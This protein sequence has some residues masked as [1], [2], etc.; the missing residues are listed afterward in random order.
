MGPPTKKL[1]TE[2]NSQSGTPPIPAAPSN[3][4]QTRASTFASKELQTGLIFASENPPVPPFSS[5]IPHTQALSTIQAVPQMT[6]DLEKDRKKAEKEQ[7]DAE[8]QASLKQA[9]TVEMP[10]HIARL[11]V[12]YQDVIGN[13]ALSKD[14]TTL[15]LFGV[16]SSE[17]SLLSIPVSSFRTYP[18]VSMK[19]SDPMELIVYVKD[20]EGVEIDYRFN[21]GLAAEAHSQANIIRAKLS[22]AMGVHAKTAEKGKKSEVLITEE[23][24]RVFPFFCEK[25]KNRWKN[26]EGLVYHENRSQGPCNKNWNR[27]EDDKRAFKKKEVAKKEAAKREAEEKKAAEEAAKPKPTLKIT[28][29]PRKA[30]AQD[31]GKQ[32]DSHEHEVDYI[33]VGEAHADS[34][35]ASYESDT[36][37]HSSVDSIIEWAQKVS[38]PGPK[39]TSKRRRSSLFVDKNPLQAIV[40]ETADKNEAKDLV[41]S[42]SFLDS[43]TDL[44]QIT[45][46]IILGLVKDNYGIFP[47]DRSLWYAV[48]ATS[49]KK[50][51]HQR[52]VITA[53]MCRNALITL[54][55]VG[56]LKSTPIQ[57]HD[58][59]FKIVQRHIITV[60]S[61]DTKSEIVVKLEELIQEMHPEY[62]VP[63]KFAPEEKHLAVLRGVKA[64]GSHNVEEPLPKRRKRDS[65]LLESS[66]TVSVST[67][68]EEFSDHENMADEAL[69]EDYDSGSV[70]DDI[71]VK[72]MPANE[73][74]YQRRK[75]L[76]RERDANGNSKRHCRPNGDR[77]IRGGV[78]SLGM[79][80]KEYPSMRRALREQSWTPAPAFLQSETGAWVVVPP[81]VQK[82]QKPQYPKAKDGSKAGGSRLPPYSRRLPEPITY[83][84]DPSGA[85]S[86][87]PFGH[88]VKPIYAR[89]SRMA[90]GN[91]TQKG[92][93]ERRDNSFRPVMQP[94]GAR[95]FLPG[96]PSK[97][98]L[99]PAKTAPR[100]RKP[101]PPQDAARDSTSASPEGADGGTPVESDKPK[102]VYNRRIS[103]IRREST[104]SVEPSSPAVS[105]A[106]PKRVTRTPRA[107]KM[108]P[109]QTLNFFLPQIVA[110]MESL[111]PGLN[112]L[113]SNFGLQHRGEAPAVVNKNCIEFNV[114]DILHDRIVNISKG[115]PVHRDHAITDIEETAKWEQEV[116]K[117]FFIGGTVAPNHGWINHST[118]SFEPGFDTEVMVLKWRDDTAF[119]VETLPYQQLDDMDVPDYEYVDIPTK[120][121]PA[122]P[123]YR[124]NE[125]EVLP[126]VEKPKRN[127]RKQQEPKTRHVTVLASRFEHIAEAADPVAAGKDLG[128][129]V[130]PLDAI[131]HKRRKET[132][133]SSE[134][135]MRLIIAVV[136]IRIITGG[137]EKMID[138]TLVATVFKD[139]GFTVNF[140]Y[141]RWLSLVR[142]KKDTIDK[143]TPR[144][145]QAFLSAY[146][147]GD[148]PSLDYDNLPAYNW[149]GL[150]DWGMKELGINF[151]VKH[152]NLPETRKALGKQYHCVEK[153][154]D[155]KGRERYYN[156]A[157]G[158]ATWKRLQ[159]VANIPAVAPL[160]PQSKHLSAD[161]IEI[162]E[163]MLAKS[164]VRAAAMTP[165][166]DYDRQI[167]AEKFN[168]IDNKI[169]EE[170]IETLRKDKVVTK[171]KKQVPG[172]QYESSY[173]FSQVI[174]R[175]QVPVDMILQAAEFKR[176]LDDEFGN[177]KECV[178]V[179]ETNEGIV[180]VITQLQ[181]HGRIRL[182]GVNIPM[183]KFSFVPDGGYDTNRIPRG[184]FNFDV[185]IYPTATYMY[186]SD[187]DVIQ[188][189]LDVD[190]PRGGPD[191]ELPAWYG[192]TD[193]LIPQLWA[194]ILV[195]FSGILA[196][197]TGS[198]VATLMAAYKS[199]LEEWEIRRLLE[200]GEK[201][202]V[203]KRLDDEVDG[204]TITEWWWAVIGQFC[205]V[206]NS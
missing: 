19:G 36:S 53:E 45:R 143:L 94:V 184:Q 76:E 201:N 142:M 29:S 161:E 47:G 22:G 176:L 168:S 16:Q 118:T 87:R 38:V 31:E 89:P 88:G 108:D 200:W 160:L 84:Q 72:N 46:D 164:L 204:W 60:P 50:A 35:N 124:M 116:A 62:Y 21:I 190:P 198:T 85:W 13:I 175:R 12:K 32:T 117:G 186:N 189:I 123:R 68:H 127:Q 185:D 40:D 151:G 112:T 130:V 58:N 158:Q 1:Q 180:M 173:Q 159:Y 157:G 141:K 119:T 188:D 51:A 43:D 138:W 206:D 183:S 163:S 71:Y 145:Q 14:H 30:V 131:A 133:M 67:D 49:L 79:P 41:A 48:F 101:K 114:D 65:N 8:L 126:V 107:A 83:M 63:S 93:L 2:A 81:R 115:K 34:L 162:D 179:G 182:Q 78:A 177:G 167:A 73:T 20:D 17:S 11:S 23:T 97:R 102:H 166:D 110:G 91:P 57:F 10:D 140:M 153:E 5:N 15:S 152:F 125:D 80:Q 109:I 24:K 192:I 169:L 7:K 199:A 90:G 122:K 128:L 196:L 111:N 86:F 37:S 172:R 70:M 28:I 9:D 146:K 103:V 66:L 98:L 106:E 18:I 205:E 42:A 99:N 134:D 6:E 202:G 129:Q 203:F 194:K 96:P 193:Q 113:P 100:R 154:V 155:P 191:G 144:F 39:T 135:E 26:K 52:V 61:V 137:L 187:V 44:R 195:S 59:D 170:A 25:C 156:P 150:V 149:K 54:L 92:Y 165:A 136:G 77:S 121:A 4:S 139:E 75:R 148:V 105:L 33:E 74:L 120:P 147:N 82:N 178:R 64:D 197:R 55:G 56:M 69:E 181:A 3:P 95:K 171:R 174:Q 132:G 104:I 27:Q